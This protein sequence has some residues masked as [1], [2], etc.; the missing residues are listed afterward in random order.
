MIFLDKIK[1]ISHFCS[2]SHFCCSFLFFV[3]YSS[4]FSFRFSHFLFLFFRRLIKCSSPNRNLDQAPHYFL[5]HTAIEHLS[6]GTDITPSSAFTLMPCPPL[7]ALSPSLPLL[8]PSPPRNFSSSHL[9]PLPGL[10]LISLSRNRDN[11]PLTLLDPWFR[12]RPPTSIS[13]VFFF[14]AIPRKSQ[15]SNKSAKKG[16]DPRGEGW[17]IGP[18]GSWRRGGQRRACCNCTARSRW[19]SPLTGE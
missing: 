12:H 19:F 18:S 16:E 3:Y 1:F 6:R 10:P 13:S 8:L 7:L 4:F 2:F 9:T 11:F 14:L 15:V 5:P 17:S